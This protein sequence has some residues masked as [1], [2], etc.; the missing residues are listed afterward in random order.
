M[1]DVLVII[2]GFPQI[3]EMPEEST[4]FELLQKAI[5]QAAYR[6]I[7]PDEWEIRDSDGELLRYCDQ[8]P[9]GRLFLNLSLDKSTRSHEIRHES[10][11]A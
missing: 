3:V 5:R 6:W 11:S 4:V 7:I 9:G 10:G 1:R 2:R 8:I